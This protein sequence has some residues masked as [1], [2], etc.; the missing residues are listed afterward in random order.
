VNC[1]VNADY[2]QAWNVVIEK[3]SDR[4]VLENP[5]TIVNGRKQML[6]G[7]ISQPRNK[8]LL[9]MFNLIGLSEHAGSDDP[10]VEK[11][12]GSGAPDRTMLKLPLTSTYITSP[13]TGDEE[14]D[15]AGDED[16]EKESCPSVKSQD[17]KQKSRSILVLNRKDMSAR[18]R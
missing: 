9:K 7:G 16:K 12:M 4:I 11:R 5:G 15:R 1:L 18:N 6:K 10:V 13:V 17:L 3:Y 2:Y 8:G 14:S